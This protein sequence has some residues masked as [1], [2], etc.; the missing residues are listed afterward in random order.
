MTDTRKKQEGYKE[1]TRGIQGEDRQ[2][3][4]GERKDA[5]GG[6][7]GN[8]GK[9]GRIFIILFVARIEMKITNLEDDI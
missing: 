7:E 9:T 3:T 2:D 8:K 4:R 5:R 1:K 6:Q